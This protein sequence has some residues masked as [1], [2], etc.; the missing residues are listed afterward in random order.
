MT[1]CNVADGQGEITNWV[2]RLLWSTVSSYNSIRRSTDVVLV[3]VSKRLKEAF[4]RRVR[5]LQHGIRDAVR[6]AAETTRGLFAGAPGTVHENLEIKLGRATGTVKSARPEAS[7][8][9]NTC[10]GAYPYASSS[11]ARS[12]GVP[13]SALMPSSGEVNYFQEH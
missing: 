10:W 6:A 12:T 3:E 13:L 1:T 7:P 11:C 9:R 2:M 4:D 5:G 8:R